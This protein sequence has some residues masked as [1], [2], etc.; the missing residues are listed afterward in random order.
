VG[1]SP[2]HATPASRSSPILASIVGGVT[3]RAVPKQSNSVTARRKGVNL[4]SF[5]PGG[6]RSPGGPTL[7]L[8]GL[9]GGCQD[10]PVV[11]LTVLVRRFGQVLTGAGRALSEESSGHRGRYQFERIQAKKSLA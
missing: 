11:P 5:G 4:P 10:L 8:T 7:D 2:R 9:A 6:R 3:P 1:P